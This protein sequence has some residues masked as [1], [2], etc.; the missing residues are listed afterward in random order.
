MSEKEICRI[1]T[2]GFEITLTPPA[3]AA[4]QSPLNNARHAWYIAT[5]DDEQAVS[6]TTEGPPKPI[7]YEI[8]PLRKARKVPISSN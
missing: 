7:A 4:L 1:L 6:T 5:K 2:S 8:R 3:N